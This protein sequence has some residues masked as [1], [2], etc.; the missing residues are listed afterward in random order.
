MEIINVINFRNFLELL[1]DPFNI[2]IIRGHLHE[3]CVTI[4]RYLDCRRKHNNREYESYHRVKDLH[5][6]V[7][8]QY[9]AHYDNPN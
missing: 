7:V 2:N 4:L 8:I 9:N 5:I 3:N 6:W 1:L